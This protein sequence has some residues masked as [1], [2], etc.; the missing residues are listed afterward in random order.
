MKGDFTRDSFDPTKNFTRVMM[1]QGRPQLDADWNEQA[2]IFWEFWRNFVRDLVGPHGG[3]E[4][5]CGFGILAEGEKAEMNDEERGRLQLLQG[6]GDFLIGSGH[7]YVDGLR[8]TNPTDVTF[9]TQPGFPPSPSLENNHHP[10]LIYLDVWERHISEVEDDSIREVALLGVSTCSRAQLVWQVKSFELRGE[11]NAELKEFDNQWVKEEWPNIVNRWQARNRGRL[12]ARAGRAS[13]NPSLE[14]TLVS[15]AS[16]YRGPGNQL[17]RVEIHHGGTVDRNAP[18]F[19]FSRENGSVIFP[20]RD[21]HDSVVTVADLGRNSAPALAAGDWVELVDDDYVLQNRAEPLRQVEIVDPGRLKVTLKGQSAST[22][23]QDSTKHPLL[24][25]WDHKQG[26]PKK[27]GLELHEGAALFR[28]GEGEKFWL[29][30]ENGVQVQFKNPN[31]PAHYRTGD[32]WLIPARV[33]TGDV[34]W[35]VRNGKHAAIGPHGVQHHYAPL[36]VVS[37]KRDVLET[38]SDCRLKFLLPT[39]Y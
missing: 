27:G 11:D 17:Y 15:P 30:L 5:D 10:Y 14:P 25:R 9:C 18:T 28:E 3:P 32:Y 37:F 19:K 12:R 34:L 35:P 38:F 4:N 8:V 22:V 1:Q 7:Y 24:R 16:S 29:T 13:E 23:G 2:A 31:E 6:T 39:H 26:D 20:I 21:V 36:A 33:A